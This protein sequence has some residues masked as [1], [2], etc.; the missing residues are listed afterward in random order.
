MAITK[1]IAKAEF[2]GDLPP[3]PTSLDQAR[4]NHCIIE[5]Q[6][7]YLRPLVGDAMYNDLLKNYASADNAKLLAGEEYTDPSGVVIQFAGLKYAL[8]YW[9]MAVYITESQDTITSHSVVVKTNNYSEPLSD[10]SIGRKVSHYKAVAGSYW[11]QAK[12][13]I[14]DRLTAFPMYNK[15]VKDTNRATVR[16]GAIGGRVENNQ[17]KDYNQ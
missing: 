12:T 11:E 4:F 17:C 1:L 15:S 16:I 9:T 13:Y 14:E 7:V 5:A 10:K 6:E 3:L 8:A 2:T